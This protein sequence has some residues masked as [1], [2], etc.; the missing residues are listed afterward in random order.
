MCKK[1]LL[2]IT[3]IRNPQ[4]A[5]LNIMNL[6]KERDVEHCVDPEK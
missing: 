4:I 1:H 2:S 3:Y 6:K 5:T